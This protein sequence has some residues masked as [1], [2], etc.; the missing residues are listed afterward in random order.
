MTVHVVTLPDVGEGVA[1]AELVR[2]LVDVGDSVGADTPV[3]EV[4][5]DKATVELYAGAAGTISYL[6]GVPGDAVAVG[7]DLLGVETG[8]GAVM[9]D[10]ST[11]PAPA[12][13]GA[14]LAPAHPASPTRLVPP[15]TADPF[16]TVDPFEIPSPPPESTSSPAS[17]ARPTA[18]PAVRR[19]ASDHGVDLHDLTGSGPDG[20]ILR[21]D[22]ERHLDL[23]APTAAPTAGPRTDERH[24]TSIIGL[25]RRIAAQVSTSASR[26]PHI[27]YVEEI[28]VTEL[29]SLR[30][31][32][33]RDHADDHAPLTPLP[34]IVR[35]VVRAL[36][37]HPEL[38]S[39][40]DDE[41]EVLTTYDAVH[42]GIATQT[43]DGLMVPVV[44]DAD[45]LDLW[46]LSRAITRGADAARDGS[47]TAAS[48]SGSTITVTSLGALGGVVSTPIINHPEVAIVG[49]NRI[50]I[51]PLWNGDTFVPRQVMNLSSSFDHRI[52]DGWVAANFVQRIKAMLESPALLFIE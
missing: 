31:T 9:P 52:V 30:A 4:M 16:R 37:H 11:P 18:A 33:T 28:D 17:P 22:V 12:D 25:R 23:N 3:A 35:A 8:G 20:R 13:P 19:F 41:R 24:E 50:R 51:Q 1:E 7:S 15:R 26:I 38:N 44:R 42:V 2:W 10:A 27:T 40:F 21:A 29:E 49:V 34:F 32:L 47:A 48:L 39:T 36:E 5:T 46:G 6:K 45:A 43:S 14:P